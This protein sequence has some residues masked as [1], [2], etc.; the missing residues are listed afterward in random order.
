M[1]THIL[2]RQ[3]D[4]P[5]GRF[6]IIDLNGHQH[7]IFTK[8]IELFEFLDWYD[9]RYVRGSFGEWRLT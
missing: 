9:Y 3:E 1:P 7:E 6:H 8:M 5:E 4:T 2:V